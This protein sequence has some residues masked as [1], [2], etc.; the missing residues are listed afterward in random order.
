MARLRR[1]YPLLGL[2]VLFCNSGRL[3]PPLIRGSASFFCD[4]PSRQN[5]GRLNTVAR[6]VLPWSGLVH[7][8]VGPRL[9][10]AH[11]VTSNFLQRRSCTSLSPHT[12]PLPPSLLLL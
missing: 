5:S 6:S 10:S 2:L 8:A 12:N 1:G 3:S 7:L 9:W 11:E 4:F